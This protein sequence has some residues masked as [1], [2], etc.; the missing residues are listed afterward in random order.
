M[1]LN[2]AKEVNRHFLE[3]ERGDLSFFSVVLNWVVNFSMYNKYGPIL[4]VE[5][6]AIVGNVNLASNHGAIYKDLYSINKVL[7]LL[8]ERGDPPF[9]F[10]NLSSY[11]TNNQ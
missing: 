5:Q 11:N 8:N 2:L 1:R 9:L 6:E 3:N 10:P 7:S 4:S